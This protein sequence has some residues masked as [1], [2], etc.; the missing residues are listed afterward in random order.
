M[1]KQKSGLQ[2]R[3]EGWVVDLSFDRGCRCVVA[4]D[5]EARPRCLSIQRYY[6][7]SL[8]LVVWFLEDINS[9]E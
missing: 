4:L 6:P 2:E 1:G 9:E 5:A 8:G 7:A 3:S